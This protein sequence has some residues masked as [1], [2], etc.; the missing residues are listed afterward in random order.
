MYWP[1]RGSGVATEPARRPVASLIRQYFS[2]G[3][4]G[5]APTVPGAD[6][7]NQITN[8]LLNVLDEAGIEPSKVLDN[9]L[10][11][12]IKTLI[13]NASVKLPKKIIIVDD[14]PYNGDLGAALDSAQPGDVLLLGVDDYDICGKFR[15]DTVP[16]PGGS[17][18]GIETDSI[19]IIGSGM[20]MMAVDKSRYVSG[21]GTVVQGALINFADGFRCYNLGVDVGPWVVDN[22]NGGVWMEGFIPG[23]HKLNTSWDDFVSGGYIKDVHFGDIKVL[24]KDPLVGNVSTFKHSILIEYIDG[25]SHGYLESVGGFYGVVIKSRNII[26]NGQIVSYTHDSASVYF[27]SDQY[28][29]CYHYRGGQIAIG[30]ALTAQPSP[31]VLFTAE[32]GIDVGDITFSVSA[33]NVTSAVKEQASSGGGRIKDVFITSVDIRRTTQYSVQVPANADNWMVGEHNIIDGDGNGITVA[34]GSTKCHIADGKVNQMASDGYNLSGGCT[35]GVLRASNCGGY[36]VNTD[37]LAYV[38]PD[39]IIATDCALGAFRT[40]REQSFTLLNSWVSL[41]SPEQFQIFD[42]GSSLHF[43]GRVGGTPTVDTALVLPPGKRP[44]KTQRYACVGYNGTVQIAVA[45]E[46]R[47]DGSVVVDRSAISGATPRGVDLS[48]VT[49]SY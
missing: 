37:G 38:N 45:V 5:E 18:S 26:P 2:E 47:S 12:S 14:N 24:M 9:Q 17:W 44:K 33:Y 6:W 25:G 10:A 8:E 15:L 29:Q 32:S 43:S 22:L 34:S 3:G 7:F 36:G 41:P 4:L 39:R 28:T 19:T 35:H 30:N 20:P 31:P 27:K 40:M 1:D 11:L 21:S 13:S 46:V 49:F 42:D 48:P 16:F 23:T